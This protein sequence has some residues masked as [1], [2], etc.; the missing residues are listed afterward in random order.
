[1]YIVIALGLS[2]THAFQPNPYNG[3]LIGL[4]VFTLAIITGGLCAFL[5]SRYWLSKTIKKKC[6]ANHRSFI[7]INHVITR[8][9]WKT[10]LL[11]RLT[12]FPYALV[13]YMLG[14]TSLKVKDF[15][16]GSAIIIVH[17]AVWLWIGKSLTNFTSLTNDKSGK[18]EEM[19]ALKISLLAAEVI[20][21]IFIAF[22]IGYKAK[23][24]LD[25]I[26]EKDK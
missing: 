2:L 22:L 6:L 7:A 4:V 16:K 12:P 23:K 24:E 1:M 25:K 5:L 14:I 3:L 19:S 10:V 8:D 18:K 9:G 11:L 26:I 20:L 17:I 21:A 15:L 13:S